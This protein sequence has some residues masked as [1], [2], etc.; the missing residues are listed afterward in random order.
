M[1]STQKQIIE[2]MLGRALNDKELGWMNS[3]SHIEMLRWAYYQA[4]KEGRNPGYAF[5]ESVHL[6]YK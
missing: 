1:V 3:T 4:K 6:K 5:G 2:K